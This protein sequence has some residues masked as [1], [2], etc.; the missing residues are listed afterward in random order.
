MVG[1]DSKETVADRWLRAEKRRVRP[2]STVCL[3]NHLT[4]AYILRGSP[5]ENVAHQPGI[6]QVQA[7]LPPVVLTGRPLAPGRSRP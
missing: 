3:L 7:G 4:V 6:A 2:H 1:P 5:D